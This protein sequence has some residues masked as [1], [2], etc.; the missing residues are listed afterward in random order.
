[1]PGS[2]MNYFNRSNNHLNFYKCV[3]LRDYQNDF[4]GRKSM[5]KDLGKTT[6]LRTNLTKRIEKIAKRITDLEKDIEQLKM[7][8]ANPDELVKKYLLTLPVN[9][10]KID[11][12]DM[13][14]RRSLTTIPDLSRFTELRHLDI[15][16]NCK[17]SSGFDRLP[18]TLKKI[19]CF[20]TDAPEDSSWITRLTNL[21]SITLSRNERIRELPD[22]SA[23]K[24]LTDVDISQMNLIRLPNLPLN[25]IKF[26]RIPIQ[27]LP[28]YYSKFHY[29][30][31]KLNDMQIFECITKSHSTQIIRRINII[32]RFDHIREELMETGAKIVLSPPRLTRLLDQSELDLDSYSDWS[33]IYKYQT[34]RVHTTVYHS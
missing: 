34:R 10:K 21:E 22:L 16:M 8:D 17:L 14:E 28:M 25:K 6:V 32:N 31:S 4:R 23:L 24:N 29:V 1:M 15:S 20:K 27:G 26:L 2:F 5:L 12:S 19:N 7:L 33:D 30:K 13:S 11:L 18:T 9:R 3:K